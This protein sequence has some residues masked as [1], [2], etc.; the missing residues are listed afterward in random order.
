MTKKPYN[1]P[2]TITIYPKDDSVIPN[3]QKSTL[4][5]AIERVPIGGSGVFSNEHTSS[6]IRKIAERVRRV[7]PTAR[8]SVRTQPDNTVVV[9]R[10]T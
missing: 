6:D 5:L 7:T 9:R 4:R 10:L 3:R 1:K 2:V 8:F